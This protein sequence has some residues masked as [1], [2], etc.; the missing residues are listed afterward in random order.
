V[1]GVVAH[2][3]NPSY[4]GVRG[5]WIQTQGWP[6]QNW[7]TL[8]EKKTKQTEL[9]GVAQMVQCLPS[10]NEVLTSKPSNAQKTEKKEMVLSKWVWLFT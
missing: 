10:K 5:R 1:L 2:T 6:R 8:S 4:A 7:E 9:V 3:C